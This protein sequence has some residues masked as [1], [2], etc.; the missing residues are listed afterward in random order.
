[1]TSVRLVKL[2]RCLGAVGTI[3]I[4]ANAA[5]AHPIVENAL[6]VVIGPQQIAVDVRISLDEVDLVEE[7]H[8][9]AKTAERIALHAEYVAQHVHVYVDG[10]RLTGEAVPARTT[11]Y[12]SISDEVDVPLI[13]YQ[14]TY[15]LSARPSKVEVEQNFLIE[16][17]GWTAP[18]VLRIRRHDQ[19][20]FDLSLLS[21]GRR[22]VFPCEWPA[23]DAPTVASAQATTNIPIIR[24]AWEYLRHGVEHI[25]S[26]PDHLLFVTA[27]VLAAT[28]FWELV[29]VVA[30]FT[31][32][33]TLTL[34]LSTLHL[35]HLSERI[36]E[37][38]IATS[39][40]VTALQNVFLP[41]SS[42]GWSRLLIAFGFGLFHGLGFAGGLQDALADLPALGLW[43]GLIFFSVGVEIGHQ[44]VILPAFFFLRWIKS[45]KHAGP[46]GILA[47]RLTRYGSLAV[48]C[49]G[50]YFLVQVL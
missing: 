44:F 15:R 28:N 19:D 26:G 45:S 21:R 22:A 8:R 20:A 46:S 38:M 47:Q 23:D 34:A 40:I 49:G 13:P 12:E 43:L 33:H 9:R 2:I 10:Q 42:H 25:L 36:V 11:T 18:T 24:T 7:D 27:L 37:P 4:L 5:T 30:A 32:A 14:L 39:I 48:A 31:A 17:E 6:D 1:V 35:V 41:R 16:Y 3:T 50:I 29:K